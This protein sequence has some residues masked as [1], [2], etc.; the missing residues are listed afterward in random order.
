MRIIGDVHGC[1]AANLETY[2][3]LLPSNDLSIQI[4]DMSI[5]FNGV[6]LPDMPQHKFFRGNHD[7]PEKCQTHP[8]YLGDFGFNHDWNIFWWSGADSID[9]EDRTQ[10]I[11]WW[12]NEELT[13]TQSNEAI[14]LYE[15]TLPRIV[16]SHDAPQ[17]IIKTMFGYEDSSSTRD[18]LD[19]ALEIHQPE[20]WIFGHHH[21][22]KQLILNDHTLFRCLGELKYIDIN[23]PL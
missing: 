7:C 14:E 22:N 16:L 2:L 21:Q 12:N 10:Y 6:E 18:W 5:G 3:N 19:V 9:K 11:D 20:L 15:K 4:G 17:S 23:I 13:Y 8:N 1:Y